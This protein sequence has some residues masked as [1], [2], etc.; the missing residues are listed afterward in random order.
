[1]IVYKPR[2]LTEEELSTVSMYNCTM[3]SG[4]LEY[5][6]ATRTLKDEMGLCIYSTEDGAVRVDEFGVVTIC[7]NLDEAIQL[8]GW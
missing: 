6:D 5:D 2:P 3:G 4:S 1:M 7:A 8:G